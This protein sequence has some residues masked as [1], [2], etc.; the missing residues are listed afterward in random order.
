MI[1]RRILA[2]AFL[3]FSLAACGGDS[4]PPTQPPP[5]PPP[6]PVN[7]DP[8]ANTAPVIDGIAALGRRPKEPSR[9]AD[10]REPIDITATVRDAET[11]IEELTYQWSATA[12]TFT[13]TGRVVT[14]TAPDTVT[15]PTVTITLKVVEAYGHPG[16]PKTFSHET[17]GT[18]TI[19][20]HDSVKEIG[21]MAGRFLT[22]FSK[23]QTNQDW[24][25]IMRDF[26]AAACP[27]PGFV[28]DE[29]DDVVRNYTYYVMHTYAVWP[30]TVTTNFGGLCP[31]GRPGDACASVP[32][33]WDSTDTRSNKRGVAEG[34]DHV[35]A[36]YSSA[37]SRW[38][39]C[40]SDF[41]PTGSLGYSFYPGR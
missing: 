16:Q 3:A 11:A 10:V 20:L 27:I 14:W 1:S 7:L 39:L 28:D 15:Q 25:D 33:R 31:R 8:P 41:A 2:A 26:N 22:E 5:P 13:G 19:S 21:D 29:K 12:G 35:T 34:I 9:F 17:T 38:W 36:V 40:S 24:R 37:Q 23:P 4:R 6:P 18:V 30:A 32:V